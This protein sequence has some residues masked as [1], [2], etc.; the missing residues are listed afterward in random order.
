MSPVDK[1]LRDAQAD[2]VGRLRSEYGV[3]AQRA[4]L[5]GFYHSFRMWNSRM[6]NEKVRFGIGK[7]RYRDEIQ[8][9]RAACAKPP[10]EFKTKVLLWPSQARTGQAKTKSTGGFAQAALS[11][12]TVPYKR[13][14]HCNVPMSLHVMNDDTYKN[15]DFYIKYVSKV[16]GQLR[17][18]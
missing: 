7:M 9:D 4:D 13:F 16:R 12:C 2:L 6:D 17:D 15:F 3:V 14:L 8:G 10:V 5:R 1:E 18:S 11:P